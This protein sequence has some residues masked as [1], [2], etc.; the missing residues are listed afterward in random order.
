MDLHEFDKYLDGQKEI[1]R[2]DASETAA[3][4]DL[5]SI[6]DE[7]NKEIPDAEELT[8][9]FSEDGI[10]SLKQGDRI[11][12]NIYHGLFCIFL[13]GERLDLC[14]VAVHSSLDSHSFSDP[15]VASLYNK[16]EEIILQRK[17][18]IE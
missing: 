18:V 3:K 16:F 5:S 10:T 11:G 1:L 13:E 8:S 17:K 15:K 9:R 6:L 2:K 4:V 7:I 12:F 14:Y